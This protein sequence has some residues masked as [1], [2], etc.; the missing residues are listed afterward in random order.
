MKTL[1]SCRGHNIKNID[2]DLMYIEIIQSLLADNKL[3]YIYIWSHM[4]NL[5]IFQKGVR[6]CQRC[7]LFL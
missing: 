5:N 7:R 4:I 2:K 3:D 1:I 6:A